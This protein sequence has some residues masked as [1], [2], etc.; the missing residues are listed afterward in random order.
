VSRDGRKVFAASPGDAAV[1]DAATGGRIAAIKG[2][3]ATNMLASFSRDGHRLVTVTPGARGSTTRVWNTEKGSEEAEGVLPLKSDRVT[4]LA[5]AEDGQR[6]ALATDAQ[7]A[8]IWD[9]R[10]VIDLAAGTDDNIHVL[11]HDSGLRPGRGAMS[12]DGRLGVSF[13]IARPAEEAAPG[14]RVWDMATGE[15]IRDLDVGPGRV[16]H[17][18]FSP[19]GGMLL[20]SVGGDDGE[21]ASVRWLDVRTGRVVF[22]FDDVAGQVSISRDGARCVARSP[23]RTTTHLLDLDRGTRL[24]EFGGTEYYDN[25]RDGDPIMQWAFS[26]DSR[27]LAMA[28]LGG[29]ILLVD[30]ATGSPRGELA[31][32][33]TNIIHLAASSTGPWL[34]STSMVDP[35]ETRL[36]NLETQSCVRVLGGHAGYV[37]HAA[38]DAAGVRLV[39]AG[40]DPVARLWRLDAESP[41]VELR[42]HAGVLHHAAFSPDGRR[43]ITCGDDGT[44]RLWN[45]ETG[46]A[47]AVLGGHGSIVLAA[48]FSPD[49][50]RILT[51]S[52]DGLTRLWDAA[53]GALLLTRAECRGDAWLAFTPGRHYADHHSA[54]EWAIVNDVPLS[55]YERLLRD[56]E[57]VAA[58]IAGRAPIAQQE[59]PE[60]PELLFLTD[61]GSVENRTVRL[62]LKVDDRSGIG[63]V[64]LLQD[65]RPI[66]APPVARGAGGRSGRLELTVEI[67]S[68]ASHTEIEARATN[69]RGVRSAP[70]KIR[71]EY[72][73]RE[74]DLYLVAIAVGDYADDSLDLR[75]AV[76]DADDLIGRFQAQQGQLYKNVHVFRQTD[77]QVSGTAVAR[78][79]NNELARARH[80]DMLLVFVAGHGILSQADEYWFLT[81][82]ATPADP[83]DGIKRQQLWD[84][85]LWDRLLPRRRVLMLDTC[86]AGV[87]PETTRGAE[88]PLFSPEDMQRM[89]DD[90]RGGVYVLAAAD[91]NQFAQ[92]H[93]GNGLFTAAILEALDG[94]GDRAPYGDGDG[95]VSIDEV[96]DYTRDVVE[97][98]SGGRQTPTQPKVE[99]GKDFPLA[100]IIAAGSA[101]RAAPSP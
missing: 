19:D 71:L 29:R 24:P 47:A 55:C 67:P 66:P 57:K 86:H 31:G 61:S 35:G 101:G 10:R 97:K 7:A 53:T 79:L 39:T 76:K 37:R 48:S 69:V 3:W 59:L 17:V 100:R 77:G 93:D 90:G 72:L 58:T 85:V 11:A 91:K 41:P 52:L 74:I 84:L 13:A 99:G 33:E 15:W 65:G 73:A 5:F 2:V 82:T 30:A 22:V 88:R 94:L 70:Q 20:A 92:E 78:L 50:N 28:M 42:G 98:R 45:A 81:R 12:P 4:A 18:Q 38:F 1:F 46:A 8:L 34:V 44:A 75:Y 63:P 26:A 23:D 32:H 62:E 64:E 87:T 83:F 43:V 49:G 16:R 95:Y 54:A 6:L 68:S 89:A 40:E 14:C 27:V 60:V 36:W 80:E 56:P 96:T 51:T 21:P 9:G 25:V